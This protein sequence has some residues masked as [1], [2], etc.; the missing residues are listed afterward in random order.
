MSLGILLTVGLIG[1]GLASF[2]QSKSSELP[3]EPKKGDE[4]AVMETSEGRIV[5]MFY[6]S[7]AP[8]HVKNFIDLS[9]K[10]FYDG[11]RFHRTINNFM[12]QGGDPNSRDLT[13]SGQWGIG[14]NVVD[15]KEVNVKAEFSDIEHVRGVLSMARAQDP[16]SASSQ[17]FIVQSDSKFLDHQYSAFGKVVS[18]MDVVDKIAR[19]P[20]QDGNGTVFPEKAVVIKSVK[21]V[22][23]PIKEGD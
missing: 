21:I 6:P 1:L 19:M 4:V 22:K 13:K 9:K 5:L 20:V 8:N 2:G 17:F 14:G 3:K 18:G 16:D 12:I 15:G 7:K 10:G 23:W 11:T